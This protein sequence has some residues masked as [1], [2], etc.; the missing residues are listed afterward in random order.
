M[1]DFGNTIVSF[2]VHFV[3]KIAIISTVDFSQ[4][5]C[6]GRLKSTLLAVIVQLLNKWRAEHNEK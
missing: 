5:K 2:F 3:P 1:S 4:P 6:V